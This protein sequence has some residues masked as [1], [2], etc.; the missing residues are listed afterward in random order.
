LPS[1]SAIA[2]IDSAFAAIV[3]APYHVTYTQGANFSHI[4]EIPDPDLPIHYTTFMALQ[5][6]QMELDGCI[7]W[8][9]HNT[10]HGSKR[11][12]ICAAV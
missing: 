2:T 5:L 7:V 9:A 1:Y 3:H 6:R 12:A 4:F 11:L 10:V 8:N